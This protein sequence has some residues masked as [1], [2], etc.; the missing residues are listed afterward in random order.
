[1][2]RGEESVTLPGRYLI[3]AD[4]IDFSEVGV[5]RDADIDG[6]RCIAKVVP[7]FGNSRKPWENVGL[8][9]FIADL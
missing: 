3:L 2:I 7:Q 6:Q 8:M 4:L 9:G 1:M 5:G